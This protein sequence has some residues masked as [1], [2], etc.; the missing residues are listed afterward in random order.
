[1]VHQK[2]H[3]RK[4]LVLCVTTHS[5]V[6]RTSWKLVEEIIQP[7]IDSNDTINNRAVSIISVWMILSSSTRVR[8]ISL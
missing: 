5:S 2:R 7:S 8:L 6:F 1:M 3:V 4:Y